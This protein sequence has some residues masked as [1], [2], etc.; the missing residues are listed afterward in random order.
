MTGVRRVC[1]RQ[2]ILGLLIL[3]ATFCVPVSALAQGVITVNSPA[4]GAIVNVPFNVH[5]TYNASTTYTKLWIDG[6]AIISDH[7]SSGNLS[8]F[9]YTVTSLAV[10]SHTLTLQAHDTSSNTT[11]S[12]HETITVSSTPPTI[13]NVTPSSQTML[14][15]TQ[16]TFNSNVPATWAASGVGGTVPTSCSTATTSCTFTAGA[17]AGAETLTASA[18]D[19]SGAS[20]SASITITSLLVNPASTSV[21]AGE[22][23]P[24]TTSPSIPVGYSVNPPGL[25]SFDSNGNF[26]AANTNGN[27]TVTATA[28]DNS[29]SGTAKISVVPLAITPSNPSVAEGQTLTF[30]ANAAVTWGATGDGS[31]INPC[32]NTTSCVFTAQ[33]EPELWQMSRPP[34]P[35]PPLCQPTRALRLAL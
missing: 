30:T 8:T 34:R 11:I 2:L 26:T 19:G 25:G 7:N 18:T 32:T 21:V 12:V 22:T 17:T 10:G 35:A 24:Y 15:G 16:F 27:G 29:A 20:G 9:D 33:F 6:V 14:E 23:Q 1:K 4:N 5:F 28:T 13:V 3:G 31:F